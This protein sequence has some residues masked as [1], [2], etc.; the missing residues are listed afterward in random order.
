M[1]LV[2]VKREH[3]KNSV[4]HT[5][6][7]NNCLISVNSSFVGSGRRTM[8]TTSDH[9]R[10]VAADDI[11]K[12]RATIRKARLPLVTSFKSIGRRSDESIYSLTSGCLVSGFRVIVRL[13]QTLRPLST[14]FNTLSK[15]ACGK[16]FNCF[17]EFFFIFFIN[18]SVL[19]SLGQRV[20]RSTVSADCKESYYV[21]LSNRH[22]T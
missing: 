9:N 15:A 7:F 8:T 12:R 5:L 17:L 21:I 4:P 18:R 16:I 3:V 6:I 1:Y 19:S 20:I 10:L 14:A 11:F 2:I 22:A 13:F